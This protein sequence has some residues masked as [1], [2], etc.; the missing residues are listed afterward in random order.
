MNGSKFILLIAC[1]SLSFSGFSQAKAKLADMHFERL[2][3]YQA[4]PMYAELA[5]KS[6]NGKTKIPQWDYVRKAAFTF[7]QLYQ[8]NRARYYY[9]KLHDANQLT[10]QDYVEYIDILRTIGKYDVAEDLLEDAY[11]V[12][13]DNHFV[14]TLKARNQQFGHLLQDSAR[15]SIEALSINSGKGD[16]CPTF[17]EEGLL[18]MSKAQNAGFLNTKYNWDNS[19][20]INMLYAPYDLDSTLK[21]G[22]VLKDAFFSRAHDGPSVFHRMEIPWSLPKTP[23]ESIPKIPL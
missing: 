18:Y 23:L 3:Y 4:A 2:E 10:E 12:Y 11:R 7:K 14:A 17:F 1:I 5:N 21:K 8:Y 15:Y 9:G 22:E 20:F 13:P 6:I 19:Y 16:F